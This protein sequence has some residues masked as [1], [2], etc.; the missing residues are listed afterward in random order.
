MLKF[1]FSKKMRDVKKVGVA[2]VSVKR[3]KNIFN[4]GFKGRRRGLF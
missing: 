1:S 3:K 4:F 2:G